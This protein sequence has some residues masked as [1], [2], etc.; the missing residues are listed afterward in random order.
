M[1]FNLTVV[2]PIL[3]SSFIPAGLPAAGRAEF[4][5]R[6]GRSMAEAGVRLMEYRNKDGADAEVL[7]DARILRKAM[8]GVTLVMDDRVDVALAADFDGAHVD[9]GDLP[10]ADARRL[11]GTD[12]VVGTSA[13]SE[14]Q[15]LEALASGADYI[16]F[17][18]VYPTTT[19]HTLAPTIGLEGVR[20]FR[21]LAGPSPALVAAAGIT[22]E[23]APAIL[24][25]GANSVAVAAAIFGCEDP[26]AEYRRW[27]AR[28]R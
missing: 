5:D 3:D 15:L 1:G 17:G 14:A 16:A 7:A 21:Q 13:G 24:E 22:L 25:A 10:V 9:A 11:L 12:R 2:Y 8:P 6:L 20:R 23:A 27:M 19:K 18:P 28:L 26:A 4:L